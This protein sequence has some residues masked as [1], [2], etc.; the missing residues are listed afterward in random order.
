MTVSVEPL[1]RLTVTWQSFFSPMFIVSDEGETLREMSKGG[2]FSSTIK[3]AVA[4]CVFP[5]AVPM[6]VNMYVPRG[7]ELV[8]LMERRFGGVTE[9]V[10]LG[11][12]FWS[13]MFIGVPI[14]AGFV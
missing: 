8:V 6:I 4:V 7:V 10:V 11:G 5:K 1:T 2:G 3:V 9:N 13:C 12:R 14:S